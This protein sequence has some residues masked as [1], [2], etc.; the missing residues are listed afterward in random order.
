MCSSKRP[1]EAVAVSRSAE[2]GLCTLFGLYKT[3]RP[4]ATM[5]CCFTFSP[6]TV[7]T[8]FCEL[9]G[10]QRKYPTGGACVVL[11][12]PFTTKDRQTLQGMQSAVRF[13][14]VP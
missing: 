4:L 1:Q 14:F 3:L 13:C 6:F 9:I 7:Q 5:K 11:R 2:P 8:S 10:K 12:V